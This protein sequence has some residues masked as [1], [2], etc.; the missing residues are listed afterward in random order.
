V[1]LA[2]Y[3]AASRRRGWTL[4]SAD[5]ADLARPGLAIAPDGAMRGAEKETP[6]TKHPVQAGR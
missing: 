5:V 4:V 6:L 3:V 1:R 2:A